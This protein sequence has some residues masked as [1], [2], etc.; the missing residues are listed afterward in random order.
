MTRALGGRRLSESVEVV[1]EQT[2][3]RVRGVWVPG[4]F[5]TETVRCVTAPVAGNKGQEATV[6]EVIPAGARLSDVRTFWMAKTD[7]R[8]IRVGTGAQTGGEVI[9]YHGIRF[10]VQ[11]VS[12]WGNFTE[13]IGL[14]EEGQDDE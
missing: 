7:V 4:A 13:I 8:A 9:I 10:R 14:R 5:S 2:G 6:R 1:H 11:A 3:R 12:V